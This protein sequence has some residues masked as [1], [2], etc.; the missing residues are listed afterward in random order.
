LAAAAAFL[1]LFFSFLGSSLAMAEAAAARGCEAAASATWRGTKSIGR[2]G[3]GAAGFILGGLEVGTVEWCGD[4]ACCWEHWGLVGWDSMTCGP[5]L[6]GSA[7][8]VRSGWSARA[9]GVLG[10]WAGGEASGRGSKVCSDSGAHC[11]SEDS[12]NVKALFF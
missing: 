4:G 1:L 7:W 6:G 8:S 9:G 5:G 3:F 2:L 11:H 10:T 12:S